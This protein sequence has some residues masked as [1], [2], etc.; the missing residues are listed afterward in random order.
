M[1]YPWGAHGSSR[2]LGMPSVGSARTSPAED[3]PQTERELDGP[4]LPFAHPTPCHRGLGGAERELTLWG[5]P[6]Q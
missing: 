2:T 1:P 4:S 3:S 6:L 5:H